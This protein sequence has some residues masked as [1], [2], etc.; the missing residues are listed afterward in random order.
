MTRKDVGRAQ[1]P[2][3]DKTLIL[4]TDDHQEISPDLEGMLLLGPSSLL[5]SNDSDFGV[6]GVETVFWRVDLGA[7]I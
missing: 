4:S 5:L 6:E 7:E 1:I 2:T 3:L